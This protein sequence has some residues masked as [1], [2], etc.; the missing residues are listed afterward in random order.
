ML[1]FSD[2]VLVISYFA[3]LFVSKIISVHILWVA[4]FSPLSLVLLGMC[5]KAYI[6]VSLC[7]SKI[8]FLSHIY[9]FLAE[10]ILNTLRLYMPY[11]SKIFFQYVNLF[12]TRGIH[13]GIFFSTHF[14]CHHRYAGVI[15]D[16]SFYLSW[17]QLREASHCLKIIS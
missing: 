11:F 2:G 10:Q 17:F 4:L 14:Q 12:F 9:G 7:F 5:M 16:L 15:P 6:F 1:F 3:E 13:P 8:L